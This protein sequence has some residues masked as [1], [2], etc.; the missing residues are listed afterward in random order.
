M[1]IT[2]LAALGGLGFV[3]L[4]VAVNVIYGRN[5]LPLPTAGGDLEQTCEAFAGAGPALRRSAVL[6]PTSWLCLTI[7]AAGLLELLWGAMPGPGMRAWAL[8]G[9]SG[10]LLQ[11]AS[12]ACIEALRFAVAD[13]ALRARSTAGGLWTLSIVLF[14]FN[15][16]FLATALL[17]FTIAG[18]STGLIPVWHAVIGYVSALLLLVGA[19]ATPYRLSGPHWSGM[20]GLVGWLGWIIWI[21]IYSVLLL[22]L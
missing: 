10:V 1:T 14:G 2:T 22:R 19:S 18:D 3:L 8:V 9:L 16:V 15:Q 17:G 11:N 13:G 4:A 21:V 5:G 20:L 12:F 6:A 7:F